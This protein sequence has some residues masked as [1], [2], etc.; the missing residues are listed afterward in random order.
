MSNKTPPK[1]LR[2]PLSD[3]QVNL[4]DQMIEELYRR[5]S[6]IEDDEAGESASGSSTSA[7]TASGAAGPPGVPGTDGDDGEPGFPGPQGS[8]GIQGPMG[9]MGVMGLDGEDGQDGV[10]GTQG[11]IGPTGATG[12]AGSSGTGGGGG[13]SMPL[14]FD[15]EDSVEPLVI[16]PRVS[17]YED[18]SVFT[19]TTTGNIDD[20]DF[21]HARYIRANN[22]TI[23]TIRGLVAGYY[24]GQV[25]TIISIGAGQV[26][27]AH[28]NA[29]S[30]A[31]NRFINMVT[32]GVTSL[33]LGVG[34]A[35]Y[36][37]DLT[38][39]R[40]RLIAHEQGAYIDMAYASGNFTAQ[41]TTWT[42]DSGD[43]VT[44]AYYVRGN[45]V[46]FK[47][48][49]LSSSTGAATNYLDAVLP[50]T[51]ARSEYTN[52]AWGSDAGTYV[53]TFP[54]FDTSHNTVIRFYK[55]NL[56]QWALATNTTHVTISHCYVTS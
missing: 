55:F 47:L 36:Q 3:Y 42:V 2:G 18:G 43:L 19:F 35:S 26:D 12:P 15:P 14:A 46:T 28:Q 7:G 23:A 33:A 40:W 32:S 8:R 50:Y 13:A 22:A 53:V 31:G 4:L 45:E 9:P 17:G 25:V 27:L 48:K 52:L 37:Y 21:R 20:L 29:G 30:A 54:E 6:A 24:D 38:T 5:V 1:R 10:P 11:P 44:M 51:C 16:F 49:V 39:A 41:G 56:T 34:V